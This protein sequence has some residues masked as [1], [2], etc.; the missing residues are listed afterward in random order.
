MKNHSA[1]FHPLT[2][3][4]LAILE[5]LLVKSFPGRDEL[6]E[7]LVDLQA[8][9]LDAQGSLRF[10]VTGGPTAIVDKRVVVDARYSDLDT[11][12]DSTPYVNVL[13]HVVDGRLFILEVY[14]DDGSPVLKAPTPS[15][16]Q[17]Y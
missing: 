6:A 17:I 12:G 4:Q 11:H 16:L 15:E 1:S 13:L 14:K 8:E 9:E 5:A 7:Q 3:E 10:Q 2:A